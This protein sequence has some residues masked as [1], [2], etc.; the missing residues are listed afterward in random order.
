MDFLPRA[1][2]V[3]KYAGRIHR[4]RLLC[5]YPR[6]RRNDAIRQN[7]NCRLNLG[8][9]LTNESTM[10]EYNVS[11]TV[12]DDGSIL[13]DLHSTT[14][15]SQVAKF[16]SVNDLRGFFSSLGL[17][18]DKVT[19]LETACSSLHAGQAY[20]ESMYLPELVVQA[21]EHITAQAQPAIGR[22]LLRNVLT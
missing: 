18:P 22:A 19:E 8:L 9:R 7:P 14:G 17:H 6:S 12:P 4:V 10:N 5:T 2:R 20:H 16:D 3:S 15:T 11:F 13:F 21:V 1:L